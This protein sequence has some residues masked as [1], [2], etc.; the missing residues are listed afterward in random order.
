M[1]L[2]TANE[3]KHR[4]WV[5]RSIK[6][7]WPTEFI[8]CSSFFWPPRPSWPCLLSSAII[9]NFRFPDATCQLT[10]P[11]LAAHLRHRSSDDQHDPIYRLVPSNSFSFSLS[12]FFDHRFEKAGRVNV[13]IY[14]IETW[15]LLP[16]SVYYEIQASIIIKFIVIEHLYGAVDL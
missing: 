14:R 7:S 16:H 3:S 8:Y 2:L 5:S 12:F 11:L 4:A 10:R 1:L 15:D 13:Y 6:T 9:A